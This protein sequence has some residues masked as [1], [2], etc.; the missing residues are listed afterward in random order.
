MT[1]AT[2]LALAIILGGCC[3]STASA[4]QATPNPHGHLKEEC[5]VCHSAAG[6]TPAHVRSDFN[7]AKYGFALAGGHAPAAGA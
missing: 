2:R 4:Q 3:A 1:Q 7:H 6:W 5:A